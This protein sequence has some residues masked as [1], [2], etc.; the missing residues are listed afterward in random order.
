MRAQ[1]MSIGTEL[2]QG[3]ITDTNATFLAQELLALGIDLVQVTQ[4]GD[5]L[6]RMTQTLERA[7]E[8]A[9]LVIC[10]GGVGP[11]E[12]DL[13][14]EMIAA[15]VG[16]TPEID[17]GL[18][19]TL[20]SFFAGRGTNMPERNRK[21]AWLIPSAEALPNPIGTAPGWMVRYRGK[22]IIAMPGVPREMFRMW[23]EQAVPRITAGMD[24]GVIRGITFRTLGIG[25]SAAEQE[26]ADLVAKDNP[27]VAT[28]AKDDGVHIR[29]TGFGDTVAEAE[30]R[31]D[32]AANEVRRR[33]QRHIYAEN[34]TPL[35]DVICGALADRALTVG[36]IEAGSG[37]R[38]GSLLTG[39]LAAR[40]VVLGALAEPAPGERDARALALDARD[41]FGSA[42]GIGLTIDVEAV[43]EVAGVFRG[44]VT[45]ALSGA[46][47]AYE[48]HQTRASLVD[49]YRRA[50]MSAV[51]LLRREAGLAVLTD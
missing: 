35:P 41:R 50:A 37:G 3:M 19:E 36:I 33:L 49:I 46:V 23:A 47:E 5:D 4:T 31:R 13:T 21:Q 32:S 42:V 27:V 34:L 20:E 48:E 12:D 9:D 40:G 8:A 39:S 18:L 43:P 38:L 17:P 15:V 29:V 10:T 14:R 2:M 26:I 30:E 51:D 44:P 24:D 25:E 16:E 45:I 28:Y 6:S 22:S 1:I 7:L 11:T